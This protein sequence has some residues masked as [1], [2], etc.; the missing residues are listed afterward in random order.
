MLV[1]RRTFLVKKP[2]FDEALDLLVQ[3]RTLAKESRPDANIRV[4]ASEYGTF[5]TIALEVESASLATLEQELSTFANTPETSDRFAAWF[6]RW[7]E[8]TAPGGAG[9]SRIG[10]W[11]VDQHDRSLHVGR[12]G[13]KAEAWRDADV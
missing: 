13:R 2:H 5:D 9:Q 7:L 11:L 8:I 12:I 4:Y 1:N 3:L 10:E 6:T